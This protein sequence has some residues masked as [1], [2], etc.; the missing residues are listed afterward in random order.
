SA[1]RRRGREQ[2]CGAP[3]DARAP[4]ER[5]L[6]ADCSQVHAESGGGGSGRRVPHRRLRQARPGEGRVD[7][8]GRRRHRRGHQQTGERQA[9]W[10]RGLRVCEAARGLDHPGAW[11]RR[12]DDGGDAAA[13]HGH[14]V[15][16]PHD[17]GESVRPGRRVR[18]RARGLAFGF[19]FFWCVCVCV[20]C[21]SHARGNLCLFRVSGALRCSS[22]LACFNS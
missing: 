11:R 21:C 6:G 17:R 14:G 3:H 10:R 1:L 2:P 16:C 13:Q 12:A 20:C 7:T 5:R 4:A 18:L 22:I 8:A 15:R 9:R 19:C